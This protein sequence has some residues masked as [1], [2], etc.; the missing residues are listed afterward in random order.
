MMIPYNTDLHQPIKW[1]YNKAPN[2]LRMID[3]KASWYDRNQTQFWEQWQENVFNIDT[4]N[5][6]GLIVWCIILGVPSGLFGFFNQEHN[7]AYGSKRQNYVYQGSD[8]YN[9]YM[10]VNTLDPMNIAGLLG[11][12]VPIVTDPNLIGGNFV[13]GGQT[14]GIPIREVRFL[15]KLRYMTLTSDCRLNEINRMLRWIFNGGDQWDYA[16]KVY[17]YVADESIVSG[18][19]VNP[20][21]GAFKIEYRI[22]SGLNLTSETLNLLADP[23]YGFLPSGAGCKYTVIEES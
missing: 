4:A 3:Q 11:D 5:A 9:E 13:G 15:L 21:S 8:K 20:I 23:Q 22:G 16:A 7:W 18:A 2:L 6:F 1:E 12:D 10:V 14:K 19:T 17:A